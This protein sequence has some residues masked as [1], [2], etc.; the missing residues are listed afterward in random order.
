[1]NKEIKALDLAI[2]KLQEQKEEAIKR[3]ISAKKDQ[4]K[5]KNKKI[6][7]KDKLLIKKLNK[8]AE[9]WRKE[10]PSIEKIIKVKIKANLL[11]T[12]NRSPYV[13]G[14]DIL[15]QD[16]SLDFDD[17]IRTTLF[18]KDLEVAQKEINKICDQADELE[19]KYSNTNISRQ[20]FT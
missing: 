7:S 14:Y 12:E 8:K 15:Y 9:W 18:E 2:T 20:I 19:K 6:S 3:A 13:D 5:R 10:G 11:W 1:M 16:K 4:E 17:L